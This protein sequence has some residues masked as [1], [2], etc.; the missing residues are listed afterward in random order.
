RATQRRIALEVDDNVQK[1]AVAQH[2]QEV[3]DLK[4]ATKAFE[5]A[6]IPHLAGG[7]IDDFKNPDYRVE[8]ARKHVPEHVP[9]QDFE[10]YSD[11]VRRL[12]QLQRRPPTALAQALCVSESGR[13]APDTFVLLRGSPRSRGARVEPGFPSVLTT[14]AP[15]LTEPGTNASTTGRR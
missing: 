11:R 7:E 13:T 2:E 9:Q 12:A 14:K 5:D 8:I 6:L 3:A 15:T 10:Y 4:K 1:A